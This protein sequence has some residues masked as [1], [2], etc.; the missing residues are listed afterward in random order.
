M[1]I[2]KITKLVLLIL[3]LFVSL[4]N[5]TCTYNESPV[6]ST[7]YSDTYNHTIRW[8]EWEKIVDGHF[9]KRLY[10]KNIT[11]TVID[12][13]VIFVYYRYN[14]ND[15]WIP[16]PYSTTYY[17]GNQQFAEEIW[18]E[19]GSTLGTL[20]INYIYTEPYNMIPPDFLYLK[21]ILVRL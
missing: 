8:N 6:Y 20:D 10:I 12:N 3:I 17:K 18:Y 15:N 4:L 11:S 9:F 16:L 2:T 21:I 14:P 1:N 13:G 5:L 19:Y 7:T